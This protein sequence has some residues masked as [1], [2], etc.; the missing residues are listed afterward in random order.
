MSYNGMQARWEAF[1]GALLKALS[2]KRTSRPSPRIREAPRLCSPVPSRLSH[3]DLGLSGVAPQPR[4]DSRSIGRK[5]TVTFPPDADE[6]PA[7][8]R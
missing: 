8:L 5:W 6:H 2:I 1:R 7:G 4:R 3:V